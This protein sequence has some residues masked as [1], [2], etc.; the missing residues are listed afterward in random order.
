[1]GDNRDYLRDPG[2]RNLSGRGATECRAVQ[3]VTVGERGQH[4]PACGGGVLRGEATVLR[5][6]RG[7]EN[8]PT[9]AQGVGA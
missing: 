9:V 2:A 6:Q 4:H 5:P 1:M 7:A 8:H 3:P